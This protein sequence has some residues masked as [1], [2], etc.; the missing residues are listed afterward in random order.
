MSRGFNTLL[1]L[2]LADSDYLNVDCDTRVEHTLRKAW[3]QMLGKTSADKI[4]PLLS[5]IANSNVCL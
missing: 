1:S 4:A 3:S 5:R 2:V